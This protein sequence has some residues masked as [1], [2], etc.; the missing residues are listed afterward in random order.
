LSVQL[1]NGRS[2]RFEGRF[3]RLSLSVQLGNGRSLR[4]EG[5]F[6]L[7]I[8]LRLEGFCR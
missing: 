5:R 3:V 4:F 8:S 1:G 7:L 6:L 2:L